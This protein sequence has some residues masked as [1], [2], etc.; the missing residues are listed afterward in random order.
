[1]CDDSYCDRVSYVFYFLV[2]WT[3]LTP[4]ILDF[5]NLTLT[6]CI[7]NKFIVSNLKPKNDYKT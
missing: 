4:D 7:K 6:Y 3:Q 5:C 2:E 1:M